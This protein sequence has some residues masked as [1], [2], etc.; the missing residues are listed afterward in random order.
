MAINELRAITTLAKA[1]ELGSLRKAAA[2]Q[3]VTPQA[4]S[5]SVALLEQHLGV[6][7]LHRTTRQLSLTEEGQRFLESTRPA[8]ASLER[9]LQNVRSSKD[10]FNGPL[11]IVGP[12]TSF[13]PLLW[14]L[15]DEF[16]REHPDIHPDVN[17]DDRIGNWVLDRADVGFRIGQSPQEGVIARRLLP[18]QLITCAA[19]SYIARHGIPETPEA[20][21]EHLCSVFRH[22]TNG[23]LLPWLISRDGD[24]ATID[25]APAFSTNQAQLEIEATLSGHVI[26]QLVGFSV[27]DHIRAGRLVPLLLDHLD[28]HSSL[29]VYY[30]SRSS[31]PQR[32][33]AFLDLT[34]ERLCDNPALILTD[35]ELR[36][37]ATEGRKLAPRR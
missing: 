15:L 3:G 32:V 10:D 7:L 17:L 8:L 35:K 16:V 29:F 30:G 33:R 27:A 2:A 1:V 18:L 14:P 19:P 36:K 28:D 12:H 37:A 6:R 23:R 22:P 5:Q 24:R 13:A 31:M 9:A 21:Q 20:L 11:R 25:L 34:I 26:G 4:A